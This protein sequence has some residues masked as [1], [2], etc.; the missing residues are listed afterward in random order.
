[1]IYMLIRFIVQCFKNNMLFHIDLIS[2]LC[3]WK[4]SNFSQ[5]IFFCWKVQILSLTGTVATILLKV[6]FSAFF[7]R[8]PN[9]NNHSVSFFLMKTVVGEQIYNC[10]GLPKLTIALQHAVDCF[11]CHSC[12]CTKDAKSCA[13][14]NQR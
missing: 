6:T 13:L 3:V 7:R 9:L 10:K 11:R 1:M 12:L 2:K 14:E 5:L 8:Y 4:L